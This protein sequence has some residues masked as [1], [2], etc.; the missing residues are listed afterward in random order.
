MASTFANYEILGKL[1][2]G[3]MG[4]V[5]RARD[6][7]LDRIVALKVMNPGVASAESAARF[8]REIQVLSR[9]RHPNIIRLF[10]AGRHKNR[11]YF[12]MDY[13]EGKPLSRLIKEAETFRD[14]MELVPHVAT[15]ARALHY[16]HEQGVIHRD[17]KPSNVIVTEGGE[18]FISDFGLAKELDAAQTITLPG[19][20]I[21]TAAYISPEQA[22][23]EQERIGPRT[24]VYALGAMLYEILAGRRPFDGPTPAAVLQKAVREDPVRPRKLNRR[25]GLDLE[26]VCLK[27]LEK[28]PRHRYQSAEA[29]ADDLD[30]YL[31]GQKVLARRVP[32]PGAILR[33]HPLQTAVYGVLAVATVVLL[34]SYARTRRRASQSVPA[35]PPPAASQTVEPLLTQERVDRLRRELEEKRKAEDEERKRE[36]QQLRQEQS[37]HEAEKAATRRTGV[38]KLLEARM[39]TKEL[40]ERRAEIASIPL[41]QAKATI[42][43]HYS[44]REATCL[45]VGKEELFWGT[46][47]GC[48]EAKLN[49]GGTRLHPAGAP[50]ADVLRDSVGNWWFATRGSGVLCFDGQGWRTFTDAD[51]LANNVVDSVTADADSRKWFSTST[52]IS[53]YDGK[54]WRTYDHAPWLG[55]GGITAAATDSHGGVWL[56]TR[57]GL[58]WIDGR[59]WKSYTTKDGLPS[60]RVSAI[61]VDSRGHVWVGTSGKGLSCYDGHAWKTY[62]TED[63]S[64]PLGVE[65][66]AVDAQGRVWVERRQPGRGKNRVYCFDSTNWKEYE[67][68]NDAFPDYAVHKGRVQRI[69]SFRAVDADGRLW[70]GTGMAYGGKS[71]GLCCFDGRQV[72]RYSEND[73][74]AH[75]RV[76]A[77]AIDAEG[78]I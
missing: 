39:R 21:G 52:G 77:I 38:A 65:G 61:A 22:E 68:W 2:Q 48:V 11:L 76:Y 13:I 47:A 45:A 73:G 59:I 26:T 78:R 70:W 23:G 19:A 7:K 1:G 37:A 57:D 44:T 72:K 67:T 62:C 49:M 75:N 40:G 55:L 8:Q 15:I 9:L 28:D 35:A 74:L 56:G 31:R 53:S 46:H 29:L 10:A 71:N 63:G 27:C 32:R 5:Y 16:A 14:R 42:T 4:T 24:D 25:I 33:D 18:P 51:G 50:I 12:S 34:L 69:T 54:E 58:T 43:S 60:N 36:E 3:G 66:I 41:A 64:E 30:R 17:I 6:P 20:A